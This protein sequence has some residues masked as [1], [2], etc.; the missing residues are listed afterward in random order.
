MTHLIA[1]NV[2]D[3]NNP[4]ATRGVGSPLQEGGN[5][6]ASQGSPGAEAW[7][8]S[9][10]GA[11]AAGTETYT[12]SADMTTAAAIGPAPTATEKSKLLQLVI[13]TDTTMLFTLQE[14]TSATVRYVL[15]LAPYV[16]VMLVFRYP[17]KLATADK[18]WFGKAS[19][20]GNVYVTTTTISEA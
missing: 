3:E 6:V 20:A 8:V 16:P 18:K 14:E 12:T 9:D 17:P 13:S 4:L 11:T 19:V 1:G 10:S 5:V 2:I 7:P 15:A